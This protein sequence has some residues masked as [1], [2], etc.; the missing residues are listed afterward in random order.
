M[1]R[2]ADGIG[3]AAYPVGAIAKR[4]LDPLPRVLFFLVHCIGVQLGAR[5][6]TRQQDVSARMKGVVLPSP[7]EPHPRAI[8]SCC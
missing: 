8:R 7:N 3:A 5:K 2:V 4:G 1:G 6:L